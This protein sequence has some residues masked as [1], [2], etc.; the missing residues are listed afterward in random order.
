MDTKRLQQLAGIQINERK[1]SFD[2]DDI[3]YRG[4][5]L[6]Q[7]KEYEGNSTTIWHCV[8]K[9]GKHI[10]TLDHSPREYIDEKTFKKYVDFYEKNGRWPRRD[11]FNAFSGPI[12]S[13]MV[14]QLKEAIVEQSS[15]DEYVD[16]DT[17]SLN[18]ANDE[19]QHFTTEKDLFMNVKRELNNL[20]M[21]AEK[22]K[23]RDEDYRVITD[24]ATSLCK[25]LDDHLES[26]Y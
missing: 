3:R 6:V 12:T 22:H 9:N 14:Q 1:S 25:E 2:K 8:K 15:D 20:R 11:D 26:Y 18:Y 13:Q 7:D 5:R 24:L 16:V 19:A 4:Y 10:V 23:E 21:F 17:S